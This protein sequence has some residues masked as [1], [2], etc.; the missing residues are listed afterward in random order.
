[1][2]TETWRWQLEMKVVGGF[3]WKLA[4]ETMSYRR[5]SEVEEGGRG[6]AVGARTERADKKNNA[7][8]ATTIQ[9]HAKIFLPVRGLEPRDPA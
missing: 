5:A 3:L 9:Y 1:M 2:T 8:T 4:A 6:V 7:R